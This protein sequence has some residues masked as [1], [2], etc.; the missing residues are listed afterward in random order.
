MYKNQ[1][2]KSKG[3]LPER[4]TIK[5]EKWRVAAL[6]EPHPHNGEDV[7]SDEESDI[8]KQNGGCMSSL[9][10]GSTH[11][12]PKTCEKL[13]TPAMIASRLMVLRGTANESQFCLTKH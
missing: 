7:R 6:N 12:V 10:I 11:D 9:P 8:I 2:R 4:R 13:K 3:A 5:K 1:G